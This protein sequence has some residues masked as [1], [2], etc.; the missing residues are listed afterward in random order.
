MERALPRSPRMSG[1]SLGIDFGTTNTVLALA[2]HMDR[3][4][5]LN[6]GKLEVWTGG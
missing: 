3:V 1:D 5:A 4:F 6:D 2:G